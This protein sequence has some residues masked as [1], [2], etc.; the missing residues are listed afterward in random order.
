MTTA[1]SRGPSFGNNAL[2]HGEFEIQ[3][4]PSFFWR[5][6]LIVL[7]VLVLAALGSTSLHQDKVVAKKEAEDKSQGV[8][9]EFLTK[10]FN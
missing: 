10:V 6:V 4:K 8:A 9:N 7:P 2:S 3:S 1:D 5:A